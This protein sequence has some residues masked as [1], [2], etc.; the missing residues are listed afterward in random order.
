M[1]VYDNFDRTLL[2]ERVTVVR[3]DPGVRAVGGDGSRKAQ[4]G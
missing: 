3:R 1:Y 4:Q 2:A